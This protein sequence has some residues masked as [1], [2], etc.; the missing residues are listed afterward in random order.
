MGPRIARREF[1]KTAAVG[2]AL[3]WG[4]SRAVSSQT[5]AKPNF[6]II[7][8]DDQG[9][10]D[11][12]CFG[13]TDFETPN[14]DRLAAEGMRFTDFYSA[15]PVCT[16]S[17]AAL[18]TG[19]YPLRAGLPDVLF[20][21]SKTGISHEE[22]TIAQLLK[23]QGYATG[24]F[25]KWHLGHH[26]QFLPTRHGF[27]V[28]Y[29][30]PYSNDMTPPKP[31]SPDYP[32]LPLLDGEEVIAENP[33]QR[34]LT[35][36]YTE[37]AIRFIEE[38]KDKPFFV[39]LPHSMPH[40]PLY[41]SEK[42]RGRSKQGLY[43]DVIMEIDW[44]VGQI[45]D[46]LERLGLDENTLVFF[47][48]DNGPWLTY[49]NHAGSAGPLRE[50]KTTTFDGGQRVPALARWPGRIPSGAVCNEVCAMF[51]L[52]PTLAGLAGSRAPGDRIIDGK[53]IAPLLVAQTGAT[54]P[55]EAIYF[56]CGNELQA[57]RSGSWKLHLAHVYNHV[58]LPGSDG[59]PGHR[60][61]EKIDTALFDLSRD[62]GETTNVADAHPEVTAHLESLASEFDRALR[63]SLRPCGNVD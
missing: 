50:G 38:H 39:Y 34:M 30:L 11:A 15:A 53:D 48:S 4:A 31:E 6:V 28:Y 14:L 37:H 62:I 45:L 35:T 22:V 20:P 17:R 7:L 42:F 19:C 32:P 49:G 63:A 46:T 1:L 21:F 56:Y 29:G 55:H 5:A 44:S 61:N 25:G 40:V 23:E 52:L 12:G 3:A 57:V 36:W 10:G 26:P 33:D 9:Y 47:T 24:C 27:D 13:A 41:V 58:D 54:S 18:M 60:V 43:G 16:P 2:G 59:V 8:T 51:D